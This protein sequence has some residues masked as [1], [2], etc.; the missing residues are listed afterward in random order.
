MLR[1]SADQNFIRLN[2]SHPSDP[3]SILL[4]LIC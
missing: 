3:R 1:M 4:Y 2:P